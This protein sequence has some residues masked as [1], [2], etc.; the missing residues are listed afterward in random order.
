MALLII[1]IYKDSSSKLITNPEEYP[2]K[3]EISSVKEFLEPFL[4]KAVLRVPQCNLGDVIE[5]CS[6]Q[7]R[8]TQ[9]GVEYGAINSSSEG[10]RRQ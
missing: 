5:L 4:K 3:H 7:V 1:V 2:D 6:E 8:G 9:L 10:N